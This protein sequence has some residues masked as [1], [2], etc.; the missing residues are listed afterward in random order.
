MREIAAVINEAELKFEE[1]DSSPRVGAFI[2]KASQDVLGIFLK[3]L[4]LLGK[5]EEV[6]LSKLLKKEMIFRLLTGDY[7]HL[8]F[9]KSLFD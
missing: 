1:G 4:Q 5:P 6:Y 2:G 9:H 3:M 8:F 7:G